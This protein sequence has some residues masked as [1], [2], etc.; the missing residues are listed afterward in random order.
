MSVKSYGFSCGFCGFA[1][2]MLLLLWFVVSAG[3]W[4]CG[5]ARFMCMFRVVASAVGCGFAGMLLIMLWFVVFAEGF[6]GLLGLGVCI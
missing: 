3:G 2:M 1:G 4:G 5:F 6:V